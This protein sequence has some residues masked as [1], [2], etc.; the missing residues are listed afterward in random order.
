VPYS[1]YTTGVGWRTDLVPDDIAGLDNPYDALWDPAYERKVGIID[2]W[3]TAMAMVGLR[4][5]ISDVNSDKPEDLAVIQQ[6]L[7][8]LS[9]RPSPR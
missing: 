6:G 1:V 5:G 3:H 8:E 9:R 7:T 4:A 2:D